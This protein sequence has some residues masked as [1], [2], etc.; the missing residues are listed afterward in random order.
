MSHEDSFNEADPKRQWERFFLGGYQSYLEKGSTLTINALH[1]YNIEIG[2]PEPNEGELLRIA[3]NLE[4]EISSLLE[5]ITRFTQTE[6]QHAPMIINTI[7]GLISAAY[8]RLR[9]ATDEKIVNGDLNE[10]LTTNQSVE[11]EGLDQINLP[12]NLDTITLALEIVNQ[13]LNPI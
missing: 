4:E 13:R 7:F 8:F 6:K 12:E 1:Q 3:H 11:I 10:V 9:V 5:S 2:Q